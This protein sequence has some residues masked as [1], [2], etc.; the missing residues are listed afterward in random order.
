MVLRGAH[1]AR[2]NDGRGHGPPVPGGE[3]GKTARAGRGV[4]HFV[5]G[6]S[7]PGNRDPRSIRR[8]EP[9]WLAAIPLLADL[10]EADLA[11]VAVRH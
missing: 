6:P 3:G 9:E 5:A 4:H 8:M 2:L 10:D 7:Q 1:R 11:A